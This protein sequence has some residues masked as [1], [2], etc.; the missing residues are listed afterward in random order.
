[1]TLPICN[2]HLMEP[3]LWQTHGGFT[4]AWAPRNQPSWFL[5]AVVLP[6]FNSMLVSIGFPVSALTRTWGSHCTSVYAGQPMLMSSCVA[7]NARWLHAFHGQI[8]QFCP[9]PLSS[10]HFKHMRALLPALVW[11]LC[12]QALN[13][14]IFKVGS[15]NGV[16]VC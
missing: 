11:S 15:N 8:L 9:C 1:M 2:G 12:P 5:D 14:A 7:A 6:I 10:A 16:D 3:M 13:F 4:L